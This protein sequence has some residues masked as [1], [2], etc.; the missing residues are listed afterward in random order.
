MINY[1]V[2]FL[3]LSWQVRYVVAYC[4]WRWKGTSHYRLEAYRQLRKTSGLSYTQA[5]R[6]V[7]DYYPP[8]YRAKWEEVK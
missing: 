3:P 7:D 5:A 6:V 1:L 4:K 2:S 8:L